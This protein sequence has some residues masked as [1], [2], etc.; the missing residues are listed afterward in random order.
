MVNSFESILQDIQKLNTVKLLQ[1]VSFEKF[2]LLGL[3]LGSPI[4]QE[5]REYFTKN[6]IIRVDAN[7][8]EKWYFDFDPI[9][10]DN[11]VY[12]NGIKLLK[13]NTKTNAMHLICL[14]KNYQ[15]IENCLVYVYT[16]PSYKIELIERQSFSQKYYTVSIEFTDTLCVSKEK[17]ESIFGK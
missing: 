15:N 16:Y 4:C 8:K 13:V 9:K 14:S 2:H 5:Y 7:T 10:V 12:Q 17:I 1:K 3:N 6:K 11:K